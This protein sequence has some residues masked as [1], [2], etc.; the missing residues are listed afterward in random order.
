MFK[1]V[2]HRFGM[3]FFVMFFTSLAASGQ[4]VQI[5]P[6]V[7]IG[8]TIIRAG[9]DIKGFAN[10]IDTIPEARRHYLDVDANFIRIPFNPNAHNEDR[11]VEI[12]QY[13]VRA[14]C[15]QFGL[16]SQARS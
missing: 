5:N 9:W 15:D 16:G 13:E 11:T 2:I 6:D 8:P 14:Q 3:A 10:Q 1:I 4:T 12:S 7:A